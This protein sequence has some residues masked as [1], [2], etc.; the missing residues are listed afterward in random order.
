M[1][2][3]QDWHYMDLEAED[4]VAAI[5]RHGFKKSALKRQV[6]SSVF[7]PKW[8]MMTLNVPDHGFNL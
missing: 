4:F 1:K 7:V 3:E 8:Q 6:Q 2:N 5:L